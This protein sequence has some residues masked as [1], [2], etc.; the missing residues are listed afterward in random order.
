FPRVLFLCFLAGSIL[1]VL[2]RPVV[3]Q[4]KEVRLA[5]QFGLHYLPLQVMVQQKLIE[6]HGS[7]LGVDDMK[8]TLVKLGSGGAVNDALLSGSV[9]FAAGGTGPLLK[10]W[11]RSR[12]NLDVRAIG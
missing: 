7:K 12:G 10:L 6:K 11:D 9:D 2:P 1:F 8:V 5:E 4:T 3:A